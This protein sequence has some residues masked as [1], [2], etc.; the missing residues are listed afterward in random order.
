V[1][2]GFSGSGEDLGGYMK[3][4]QER[5]FKPI[6]IV[7]ETEDEARA[8]IEIIDS[9]NTGTMRK[10]LAGMVISI[11]QIFTTDVKI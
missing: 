1:G 7:L 6:T 5:Q 8:F 10:D 9:I 4:D 2:E 11:S 3:I